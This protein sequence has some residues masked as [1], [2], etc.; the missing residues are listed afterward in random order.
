[1]PPAKE[2]EAKHTPGKAAAGVAEAGAAMAKKLPLLQQASWL[3][4]TQLK[5]TNHQA[6]RDGRSATQKLLVLR[7]AQ[8][9]A[10]VWHR[11]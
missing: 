7:Q 9:G 11:T 8:V 2:Q 4:P 3:Q 6:I 5:W 10:W 1:M